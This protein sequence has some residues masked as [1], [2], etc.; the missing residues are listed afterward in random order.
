MPEAIKAYDKAI[1][2]R[3]VL[4][5]RCWQR[6]LAYYFNDQFKLG[7]EQFE[8]HQTVNS[9]DVENSVWHLLCYS[10]LV[11]IEEARK[12]MIPIRG[13]QRV[14]MPEVLEMF[15]GNGSIENVMQAA[16]KDSSANGTIRDNHLYYA[17]LYIGLFHDMNGDTKKA[18]ESMTRAIA[19]NPISKSQ[20]MGSVADVY[21]RLR[22]PENPN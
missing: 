5:P 20:L 13:D 17:H 2:L 15:A 22:D 21:L 14:P 3:P 9:Q 1:E 11:G 8:V 16:T 18:R 7:K 4:K 19:V 10:R 12:S 6:G